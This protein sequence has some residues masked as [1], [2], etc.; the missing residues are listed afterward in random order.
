[1]KWEK[2]KSILMLLSL[3]MINH[4]VEAQTKDE[5]R[6]RHQ[7]PDLIVDLG[8][9]LWGTPIPVDFDGDGLIDIINSC[10]DTPY[11][12]LYLFKNIGTPAKPLF[13]VVKKLSESTY[14]NIQASYVGDDLYVI[15]QGT[16]YTNFTKNLFSMPSLI[17][18]D[19]LP[20]HDF[21]RVRS[22]MWSYVDFDNDSDQDILVGIDDWGD[23]GWDNAY[24]KKGKWTNGPLR[25]FIYL[26]ENK[27]GKYLNKGKI[28]AGNQ[29]LET[30]G[31]P[32]ANMADF[33]NDGLMDII[34]GEFVD[35]LSW[36]KNIG[37]QSVP[38]F[39][40]GRFLVDENDDTIRLHVEMI[41]PVAVDFDKD[42]NIDLVV[43]DE[44]GRVAFIRNTGRVKNNM[45]VFR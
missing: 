44:D 43:G 32:G 45:P 41:T 1:M 8:T 31:A 40:E 13:D 17:P 4:F 35:K 37:T 12:G 15:S 23:Y 34:C 30:Y 39:S 27:N 5:I 38:K 21:T 11:K 25:G 36:F 22:N 19:T 33:D 3:I 2:Y 7:N 20:G 10:P 16:E 42:G 14:K 9:G 24:D 6:V 18:V 28:L 29:P 26:L